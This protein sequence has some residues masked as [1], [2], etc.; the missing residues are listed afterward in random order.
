MYGVSPVHNSVTPK[1]LKECVS[2]KIAASRDISTRNCLAV[3]VIAKMY[4][5]WIP[6]H[7]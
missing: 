6:Q 3:P 7:I 5:T 1:T 2:F 4:G